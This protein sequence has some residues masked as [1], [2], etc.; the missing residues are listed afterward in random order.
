M[1][2]PSLRDC[3]GSGGWTLFPT[4]L[5]VHYHLSIVNYS[6]TDSP[7]RGRRPRRPA[8]QGRT[9]S[10]TNRAVMPQITRPSHRQMGTSTR[11]RLQG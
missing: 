6:P 9:T 10:L 2:P 5:I 8:H 3:H 11:P 1:C 4:H 7:R